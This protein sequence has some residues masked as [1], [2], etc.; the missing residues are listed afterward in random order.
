MKIY[1]SVMG[2]TQKD[3]DALFARL[4]GV[5]GALHLDVVDGKFAPSRSLWFPFQVSPH[6]SYTVHLM[7][8]NPLQWVKTHTLRRINLVLF[9]PHT[10]AEELIALLRKKRKQVGLAL[11]PAVTVSSVKK[12]L[13]L[14]DYIL[15]LTVRPGFY[16]SRYVPSALRKITRI[17]KINPHLKIV[18]DGHMNPKT[19]KD[20]V[21]AGADA[22][23]SGSFLSQS[24]HPRQAMKELRT[25]IS[26]ARS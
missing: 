13:P 14:V 1:P 16:G 11:S 17:K 2:H 6:F 8:N 3:I 18:V 21:R 22:V 26:P 15:V 4:R 19:V 25:A 12:V 20:A 7:V 5:A 24:V 10:K 9:H 23:V